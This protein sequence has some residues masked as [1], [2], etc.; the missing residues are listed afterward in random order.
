MVMV[1]DDHSDVCNALVRLVQMQ[2][3]EAEGITNPLLAMTRIRT[4]MPCLIILDDMMPGMSGLD[5]LRELHDTEDLKNIPV[6]MHSAAYND[7]RAADA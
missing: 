5:L 1:I 6:A 4:K 7:K 3:C 2:G